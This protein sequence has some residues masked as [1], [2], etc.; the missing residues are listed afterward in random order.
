[1]VNVK[2]VK[3]G[4]VSY[5]IEDEYSRQQVAL[6]VNI[7]DIVDNVTSTDVNKPLSANQGKVLQG[8]IDALSIKGRFLSG[9][10]CLTGLPDTD[11]VTEGAYTYKSGDYYV[12][13][14]VGATN[15]I[16]SGTTYTKG[17][18]STTT[19]SDAVGV[20]DQYYFDG[21]VW[22]HVPLVLPEHVSDVK[23]DGTSIVTG[24]IANLPTASDS[25]KGLLSAA[26]YAEFK[27]KQDALVIEQAPS[28]ST[29]AIVSSKGVKDAVD[30]KVDK[31]AGSSLVEDTKVAGYDA[32]LAN[33]D[34]HVTA[35][36][37]EVWT[38]KQDALTFD[39][40]PTENSNNPVKSGGVYTG[41]AGKVDKITGSS[42]VPDTKVAD[43]DEHIADTVK[44]VTAADKETWSGKQNAIPA[45]VASGAAVVAMT[46]TA[47]T[48]QELAVDTAVT[49]SSN[50]LVTSGAVKSAIDAFEPTVD[51]NGNL[52]F[53]PTA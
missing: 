52:V 44:H 50:N 6:K 25:A 4:G 13:S 28:T 5:P 30:A 39:A 15:L 41:L 32:H 20:G 47:G 3:I 40:T 27:A 42:L 36:Q 11:P 2:N 53:G 22:S 7:T 17:V 21:T 31:V 46:G 14:K 33:A 9:W 45:K 43:Y 23:L 34:I 26:D 38:A 24:G 12:V 29:T 19:A 8:Q 49:A 1:M 37:K 16:P 35:A 48:V 18:P 51:S 10:N